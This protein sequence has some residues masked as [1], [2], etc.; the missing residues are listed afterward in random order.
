MSR[1]IEVTYSVNK[2]TGCWECNSHAPDSNGYPRTGNRPDGER[3][4]YRQM[5]IMYKGPIPTGLVVRHDCDNRGC[6]NPAHL[7]LGTH[8]DN[9]RDAIERG[10]RIKYKVKPNCNRG[11]ND[12]KVNKPGKPIKLTPQQVLEI[13]ESSKGGTEIAR[14]YNINRKTVWWIRN[15]VI[16]KHI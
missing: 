10:R 16:W 12:S 7:R 14:L 3:R 2:T 1:K 8:A 5:Y 9:V 11:F 6:I 15:Y 13:R 4:I